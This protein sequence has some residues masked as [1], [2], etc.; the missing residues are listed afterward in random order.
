MSKG[1]LIRRVDVEGVV[2]EVEVVEV[3]VVGIEVFED[4]LNID[5]S[6]KRKGGSRER[7]GER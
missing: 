3:V 1:R 4:E 5:V 7:E 6:I 2:A